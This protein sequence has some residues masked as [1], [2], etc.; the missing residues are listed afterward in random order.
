MFYNTCEWY[1]YMP[2]IQVLTYLVKYK[3]QK[4]NYIKYTEIKRKINTHNIDGNNI[5]I[6]N[7][8]RSIE[9]S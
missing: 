1:G 7:N 2:I 6:K 4:E 5:G 8:E 3:L 9:M